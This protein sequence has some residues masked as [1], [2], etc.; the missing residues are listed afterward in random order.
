MSKSIKQAAQVEVMPQ[1]VLVSGYPTEFYV[2]LQKL[3]QQGYSIVLNG[4]EAPHS[5]MD[6]W[7]HATLVLP[8]AA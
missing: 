6:G 1:K 3:I 8:E 7:L 2:E 4:P 5:L